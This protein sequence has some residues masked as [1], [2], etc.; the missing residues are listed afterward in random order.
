MEFDIMP[1]SSSV[2]L[3]LGVISIVLVAL[4]VLFV[5]LSMSAAKLSV[6]VNTDSV[7]LKLPIYSRTIP[8]SQLEL[9]QAHVTRID[10]SSP[11]RPR[12]R[13]N[14]VGLPGYGVGWFKLKN[15]EKALLALTSREQVVYIPTRDGYSLLLSVRSPNQFLDQLRAASDSG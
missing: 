10:K 6:V 5:W 3:I 15:G 13:T 4:A 7:Q 12:I 8:L 11:L 2:A 9:G 1:P 14:G